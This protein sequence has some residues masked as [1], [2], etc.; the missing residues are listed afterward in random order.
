MRILWCFFRFGALALV[1]A[2]ENYVRIIL[3]NSS[4]PPPLSL[5]RLNSC[6]NPKHESPNKTV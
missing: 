5:L 2:L 3:R 6:R 4:L 1:V